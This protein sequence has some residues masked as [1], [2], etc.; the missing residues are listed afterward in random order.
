M[1]TYILTGVSS[2][3][4][5][6]AIKAVSDIDGVVSVSAYPGMRDVLIIAGETKDER[7]F[8][9]QVLAKMDMLRGMEGVNVQA[10]KA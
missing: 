2:G 7:D 9:H 10:R 4:V 6:Q 3:K 5:A 8:T 1:K